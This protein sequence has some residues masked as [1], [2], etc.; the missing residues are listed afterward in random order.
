MG[1]ILFLYIGKTAVEVE[2]IGTGNVIQVDM[3]KEYAEKCPKC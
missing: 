2:R 1:F 3:S